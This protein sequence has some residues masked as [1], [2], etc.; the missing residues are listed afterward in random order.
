MKT[1]L[2]IALVLI[3]TLS[4]NAQGKNYIA[5]MEKNIAFLDSV[6]GI[7]ELQK[8]ANMFEQIAETEKSE[9]LPT[10]YAAYCYASMAQNSKGDIIDI[11]C[12]KAEAFIKRAELQ[13]PNNSEI[14]VIK[15]KIATARISVNTLKRGPKY[16]QLSTEFIEK[17]K[18]LNPTNPRPWLLEGQSKFFTPA[19]FGGGKQKAKPAFEKAQKLYEKFIPE[20]S[21]HPIWGKKVTNYFLKKCN[22]DE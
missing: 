1:F 11:Y 3:Y 2:S 7:P 9:W 17:A 5:S 16:G 8:R 15:G 12:D 6:R 20:S 19:V 10:Y 18:K 22:E 4:A 21:I 13:S 14:Y